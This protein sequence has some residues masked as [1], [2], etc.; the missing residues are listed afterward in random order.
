MAGDWIKI[1]IDLSDDPNVYILSDIVSLDVPTVVGHLALFWGWMDRHTPDGKSLRLTDAVIDKRVGVEGF[2]SALRQVGWLS[3][4]DMAL[5]LPNFDRHNGNSAKARALE[6]EAKRLRRLE[7]SDDKPQKKATG[8]L[9][10]KSVGQPSDKKH[11]ESPTREEK[12]REELNLKPITIKPTTPG[13]FARFAVDRFTPSET[14]R[15]YC[16][17][18]ELSQPI[19]WIVGEFRIWHAESKTECTQSGWSDLL[20]GWVDKNRLPPKVADRG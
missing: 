20:R 9:E 2:S 5:E 16:G 1:R 4:D 14:D 18:L 15:E 12:R 17:D 10:D 11:P 6:S 19:D 8:K 3:G 7:K 13:E